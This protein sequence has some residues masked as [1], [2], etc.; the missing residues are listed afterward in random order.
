MYWNL[1]F[2]VQCK[3]TS[4]LHGGM[5]KAKMRVKSGLCAIDFVL[6]KLQ[7]GIV[8]VFNL[9]FCCFYWGLK[10]LYHGDFLVFSTKQYYR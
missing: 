7:S 4:E 2:F 6:N 3:N 10:G 5:L 1:E 8:F 9:I